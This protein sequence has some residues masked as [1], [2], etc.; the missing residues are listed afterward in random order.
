MATTRVHLLAKE[1]GV[2]S[3]AIIEKCQA[4]ELDVKNHMS[5]I[6]AGLAAT[7]REWF[8]EGAHNTTIETAAP[9]DLKK[10][11]VKKK[12]TEKK[13]KAKKAEKTP[14][15]AA[16]PVQEEEAAPAKPE[17]APP[18]PIIIV[19]PLKPAK[20]VAPAGPRLEKPKPAKLSGPRVIRMEKAE[21]IERP[22]PRQRPLSKPAY[23]QQ[24]TEPL[25]ASAAGIGDAKKTDKGKKKTHG[26]RHDDAF[27]SEEALREQK[28]A[29]KLR[30]RDLEERRARLDAAGGE[31]MRLRPKRKLETKKTQF[32]EAL[33]IKPEKAYVFEPITVKD[34]AAAL[35]VKTSEIV[36]KLIAH[37]IMA[38]AN[39]VIPA[40][41]AEIIALDLGIEL[42]V[43]Q[44]LSIEQQIAEEFTNRPKN[45]L[46][47][48]PAVVTMLG[49]VDHGK[50]SLLDK[51]RSAQVAA[52]EAGGITQHIGAY[53]V[54]WGDKN[55]PKRVTF[56]DTP[57]H[58]AFTEM[59][60]RGANMTD[61]VVLVVAADDG[62]MPQT[63]EAIHHAKAAGVHII[64]ALNKID[65]P[66][67]DTNRI[68]GQLAEHDLAPAEWGG[69]TD[70]VK[71]SATKGIGIEEL[72]EHLDFATELLD[73]KADPIIPATG[74][75]V[76]AR[77]NPSKGPMAT[78]LIKEGKLKK[79]DVLL[80]GSGYGRIRTLRDSAGKSI[81]AAISSMPVEI[82]GLND[83]PQAG[84]KFYCLS[85]INRAKAAAEE[86]KSLSRK[87]ALATRSLV[88]MENLFSRIEAG[89]A[90]EVNI[91]VRADVQGSVDVLEKYLTDI[92]TEEVQ[93]KILHAAVGGI[94][95]GDVVL[96]EASGALIIGFNVVPEDKA[97]RTAESKGVDIRL[98]N[99][100]YK[101]TDDLKKA[102]SGM[103]E[104]EDRVNSL[105]KAV[106]R[107]TFKV[108]SVGTIAG[109]YVEQGE[110][111][112]NAKIRLIR[113]NIILRD[114]C[115]IESLKHFK[116]DVRQ[117]RAGLECGIKI[118]GFDDIKIG[119]IFE[120]YEVVK[121]Q[122]TI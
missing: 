38:V 114:N 101:I 36:T 75:V 90:K 45:D 66:G 39:Q 20:P 60:A 3:K 112:R 22:K 65:L 96:A 95:E 15:A 61:I 104:P 31:G 108:S 49:H 24:A 79:G 12:N 71:T 70:V 56:L 62:V 89:K 87:A 88:T 117:V 82:S 33:K 10:V 109:C 1:L 46:E 27:L 6:S 35:V 74:W 57:G 54:V 121:V 23:K 4:E 94:T 32:E 50:T 19:E 91:I 16:E 97:A 28:A 55:N 18:P 34:L 72:L 116:D 59:R 29:R 8:S 67:V 73:L 92:S 63:I 100:I 5:T 85:D 118:A 111:V 76:E 42:V 122:R 47:K 110:V 107:N 93:V 106:V 7:I 105:G 113:D 17:P 9:V 53:Q 58:E 44:K 102:M 103:L 80:A 64:I 120:V 48:R 51:I 81:S 86:K 14:E 68:Y 41:V 115:Q 43:Q 13:P 25:M 26:R 84:D 30:E 69:K 40:D 37:G 21:V 11:R 2:N 83:V 98:Y 99:I 52:G 119:D 77:L 78:L